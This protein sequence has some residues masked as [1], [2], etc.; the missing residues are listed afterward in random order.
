MHFAPGDYSIVL[1]V[2]DDNGAVGSARARL[3]IPAPKGRVA[4]H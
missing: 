2:Q 4:K 1:T 3:V